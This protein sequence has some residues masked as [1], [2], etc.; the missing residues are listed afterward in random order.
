M[1][2]LIKVLSIVL[3]V[4]AVIGLGYV[5][6]SVKKISLE[7][8][9]EILLYITIPALVISSLAHGTIRF[10]DLALISIAAAAVVLG[11][12]IISYLYL[13]ASGKSDLRGFYLPTMFM[14]SGNL[15]FPLALLAFGVEGLRAA[16]LFYIA[17]SL[18]VYTFGIYIAKGSGGITE[19]FKLPLVYATGAGLAINFLGIELDGPV[20][21]TLD[22][23][24]AATIPL[25]QLSLG[26]Y[27]YTIELSELRVAIPASLIRI[28]GGFAIA[29][30]AVTLLG[31]EGVN[32]KVVIL[33]S[34]MPS[35][36]ITFIF[37][38]KY[39]LGGELTASIV[40]LSTFISVL[41]IPIILLWLM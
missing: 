32:R 21:V 10:E 4:F 17:V 39:K 24:G 18:L 38:Y 9:V 41:T 1:P 27:L 25:M 11:T 29:C 30:A 28:L 15:P 2:L 20:L 13:Y 7:P 33:S 6:A 37:S 40:A 14:N 8:V 16:V 36:V 3:P 26:Y 5:F 19:V 22:M 34:A 12:G 23:L 35:A 31:I